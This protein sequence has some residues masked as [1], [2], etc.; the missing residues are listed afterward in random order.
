MLRT[1]TTQSLLKFCVLTCKPTEF[2]TNS[3]PIRS[4]FYEAGRSQFPVRIE[5][6]PHFF[7]TLPHLLKIKL[8]LKEKPILAAAGSKTHTDVL[9]SLQLLEKLF[10]EK[11]LPHKYGTVDSFFPFYSVCDSLHITADCSMLEIR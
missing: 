6:A 3:V 10:T 7:G 8:A 11:L 4:Y 5:L 9:I 1:C 2:S